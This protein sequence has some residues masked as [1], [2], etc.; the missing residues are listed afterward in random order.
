MKQ[1]HVYKAQ[2][3]KQNVNF[4]TSIFNI[5]EIFYH[6]NIVLYRKQEKLSIL[7]FFAFDMR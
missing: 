4:E 2:N 7:T 5:C 1:L 6:G 3:F